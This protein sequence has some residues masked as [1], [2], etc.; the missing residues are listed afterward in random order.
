MVWHG[1]MVW[2]SFVWLSIESKVW[3][4]I[5]KRIVNF[6]LTSTLS[7]ALC[8]DVMVC[9]SKVGSVWCVA[10]VCYC[11][12]GYNSLSFPTSYGAGMQRDGSAPRHEESLACQGQVGANAAR[13]KNN[14]FLP[15]LNCRV[16]CTIRPLLLILPFW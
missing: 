15:I 2:Y 11:V 7:H 10:M 14:N 9:N 5:V 4:G 1:Q 16:C 12:R 8:C 3:Y 13:R 6:T